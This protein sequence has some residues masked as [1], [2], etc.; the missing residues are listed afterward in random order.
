MAAILS[1]CCSRK[2][3]PSF[4]PAQ[5]GAAGTLKCVPDRF[6]REAEELPVALD[7]VGQLGRLGELGQ[8]SVRRNIALPG[9]GRQHFTDGGGFIGSQLPASPSYVADMCRRGRGVFGQKYTIDTTSTGT[10]LKYALE[11]T[12]VFQ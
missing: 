1:E 10:L 6:V 12:E 2:T 3:E 7:S 9:Q 4:A 8:V 11:R 5:H